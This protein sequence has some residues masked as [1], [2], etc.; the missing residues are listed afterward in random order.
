VP[1]WVCDDP[2]SPSVI[3]LY[4]VES[5]SRGIAAIAVAIAVFVLSVLDVIDA[6][7]AHEIKGIAFRIETQNPNVKLYL[8]GHAIKLTSGL[9]SLPSSGAYTLS[10]SL[11]NCSQSISVFVDLVE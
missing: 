2:Q 11:G 3:T 4:A 5:K 10:A 8:N 9:V 7:A 6:N 1:R